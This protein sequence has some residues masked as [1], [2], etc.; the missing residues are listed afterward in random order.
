MPSHVFTTLEKL[1]AYELNDSTPET[2]N[3]YNEQVRFWT[4]AWKK[5][6]EK[7]G[8][9]PFIVRRNSLDVA[10]FIYITSGGIRQAIEVL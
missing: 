9:V 8:N 4:R 6:V 7:H 10:W 3:N 5:H 1:L 2:N